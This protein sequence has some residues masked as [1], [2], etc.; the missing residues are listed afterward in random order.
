METETLKTDYRISGNCTLFSSC[1]N[2][3]ILTTSVNK[4]LLVQ[5]FGFFFFFYVYQS[6]QQLQNEKHQRRT[7]L[8]GKDRDL[9]N[10]RLNAH[11]RS[12]IDLNSE[13]VRGLT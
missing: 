6:E 13:T 7:T 3:R 8:L 9:C 2:L 5:L 12:L 10:N 11:L 1:T 4:L